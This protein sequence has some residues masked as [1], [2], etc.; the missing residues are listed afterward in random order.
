MSLQ[1]TFGVAWQSLIMV[2][3]CFVAKLSRKDGAGS[4][5]LK[6]E[7]RTLWKY[8]QRMVG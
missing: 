5:F 2:G 4:F 1:A 3:D 8:S 6:K 7:L